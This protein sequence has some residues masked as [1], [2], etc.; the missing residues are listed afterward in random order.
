M[1][2][3]TV[4][5]YRVIEK[6]G[7]GG[8][9]IVYKAEDTRLNRLVALKFLP[10]NVAGDPHSLARFQREAHAASALNHANICTIYDI[11]EH[12]GRAFIAMEFLDG[13]TLKNLIANRPMDLNTILSLGIEIADA[14]DAAH[15]KGIVHRDINPANIFVTDRGHAKILDFGLAKLSAAPVTGTEPTA[16]MID[17]KEHLTS[18]GTILGTVAYMSP[19][20]VKGQDLDARTDLF[21]LGAVLYQMATGQSA[22]RGETSG[23]IFNAILERPPV[24]AVRLNP[25]VPSKLEE[26]ITK[27]LEKDRKL[28]YQHASEIGTDLG[29]L[30]RDSDSGR[31][32]PGSAESRK[33][34]TKRALKVL[35]GDPSVRRRAALVITAFLVLFLG[36]SILILHYFRGTRS[37]A[38]ETQMPRLKNIVVLPFISVGGGPEEQIYCDGFTET[39][40]A[41][42]AQEPS[43]QVAPAHE[44]RASNITSIEKARTEFGANLVLVASWQRVGHS[45]R[46]NLSL[47]D[48]KSG[49]QLRADTITEPAD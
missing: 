21:S 48:P 6:L 37:A 31:G 20:Q 42:L 25:E 8:M 2:N 24:P 22:F 40:T 17:V 39:V 1:I 23:L 11:D 3:Q 43:L 49:K 36:L 44:I 32:G 47:I 29:R 26:I 13:S 30:K 41:K 14:L 46:I 28:R 9:G 27:A 4:S 18:P 35:A 19:E 34:S 15:S 16:T 33:A 45:A 38:I 10:E 7:G 5:H 12:E